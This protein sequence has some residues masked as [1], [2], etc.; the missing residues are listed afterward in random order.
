MKAFR[1]IPGLL[2]VGSCPHRQAPANGAYTPS[3]KR[4]WM[5]GETVTFTCN[6]GYSLSGQEQ[7]RCRSTGSWSSPRPTC[8]RMLVIIDHKKMAGYTRRGTLN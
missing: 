3:G 7:S 6:R 5:S 1:L 4:T 2:L 8:N